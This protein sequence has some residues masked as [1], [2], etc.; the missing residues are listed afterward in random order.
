M[1]VSTTQAIQMTEVGAADLLRLV[2]LPLAEPGAGEVLIRQTAI[3]INYVDVYHRQG[4]YAVPLPAVLGVEAA[5]VVEAV[6]SADTGFTVGQ[7]VAY[8]SFPPGAYAGHRVMPAARVVALPDGVDDRTAAAGLF[9][10]LTAHYLIHRL[11]PAKGGETVL[12]HAAAGGVGLIAGQ[13]L[14]S[15]GVRTIGTVGSAGKVAL[16]RD[17]GYDEV[18]VLGRDDVPARVRALTQGKGVPAVFDSIG[19]DTI[20]LSLDSLAPHGML[21]SFGSASGPVPPLSVEDLRARGSLQVAAPTFGTYMAN[22]SDIT[23]SAAALFAAIAAGTIRIE[24]GG[25]YPLAEAARAHADLE[26]RR[27]TGSLLLIP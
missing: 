15:L 1:T 3:G 5:G 18:L 6:G 2:E 22:R 19:K 4:R 12:F 16:A 27:T 8:A 11:Y 14:K 7:R 26:G 9:A 23:T 20:D 25:V 21:V 13:W 17:H 10:G 24:V